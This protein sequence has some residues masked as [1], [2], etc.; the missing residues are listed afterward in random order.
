[1]RLRRWLRYLFLINILWLGIPSNA[2]AQ[3]DPSLVGQWSSGPNFPFFPPHVH[4]L[5]TGK[6]M[7]WPGD[8]TAGNDPRQW[9]PATATTTLLTLPGY[10]AFCS[11]HAFMADGRLFVAGGHIQNDIGLQNA[12]TY[13]PFTNLWTSTPR[14]PFHKSCTSAL[15][16]SKV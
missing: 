5:P 12:S 9:D 16:V 2:V 6:V 4:M 15:W 10:D 13:N 8:G 7:I 3:G 14:C 1:M 11:G